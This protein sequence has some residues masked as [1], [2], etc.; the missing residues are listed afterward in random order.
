M[1]IKVNWPEVACTLFVSA[2][3]IVLVLNSLSQIGN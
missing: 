3:G 2:L 1:K